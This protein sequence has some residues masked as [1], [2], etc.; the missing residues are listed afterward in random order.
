VVESLP[1]D[2]DKFSSKL[3][4]L[5][6]GRRKVIQNIRKIRGGRVQLSAQKRTRI[7]AKTGGRCHLCGGLIKGKWQADHVIAY[8]KGGRHSEENY[9]PAH[10]LCNNYRWHYTPEEFQYILKL[11]VWT[12]TQIKN[13]TPIGRSIGER[14]LVHERSR[15]R[16]RKASL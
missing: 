9:L 1:K 16:R 12:R 5:Q 14:F 11:G 7:L 10:T 2:V 6:K 13:L 15:S 4:K 3:A 8:S